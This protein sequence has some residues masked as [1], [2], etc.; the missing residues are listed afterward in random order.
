VSLWRET[1]SLSAKR[2]MARCGAVDQG[3]TVAGQK[4]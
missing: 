2:A 3:M 4:G 1:E